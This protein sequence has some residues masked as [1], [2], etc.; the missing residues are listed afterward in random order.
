MKIKI[1]LLALFMLV[2][3]AGE[4]SANTIDSSTMYFEGA[5][6]PDVGGGYT[7]TIA[8]VAG[9]YYLTGP[10]CVAGKTPD[11]RTCVGGWDV[12]A[13]EGGTAYYDDAA[14]GT[15]G[16]DHD[17][18]SG[19]GGWGAFWD[20]DVPDW[21]Y[22]QVTFSD[23]KWYLEYKGEALGTP[24][25]GTMNWVSMYAEETDVGSY[26]GTVP[27]GS[28]ANDGDAV[29]NGGGPHA[30]DMDWTW[31]SEAIPMECQGFEVTVTQNSL[32]DG[33]Y[34]VKMA[35]KCQ[36][37][38]Q[39]PDGQEIPEFPTAALP[40]VIAVGGYLMLRRRKQE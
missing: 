22:Y 11:G 12:Y 14:Q 39:P 19:A 27:A 31:G 33:T 5:L 18:Y 4:V 21:E 34:N 17:G 13:K 38:E 2:I 29:L 32:T 24:M 6:T 35:P 3:M 25:S 16:S 37:D 28:D 26:R 30:W 1:A 23:G 8:A 7:G 9:T 15:I 10:G 36:S 40:A 20:P